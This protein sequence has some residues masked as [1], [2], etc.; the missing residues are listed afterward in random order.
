MN[1]SLTILQSNPTL[2]WLD[3]N[4]E[5]LIYLKLLIEKQV[6]CLYHKID[7][8]TRYYVAYISDN[9]MIY[10]IFEKYNENIK[11]TNMEEFIINQNALL[12]EVYYC[13]TINCEHNW[14][15]IRDNNHNNNNNNN[16]NNHNNNNNNN[17]LNLYYC[18]ICNIKRFTFSKII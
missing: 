3:C 8:A 4:V 2:I 6:T 1:A 14:T 15:S 16:N 5:N 10:Y 12:K 13:L 11:K 17:L 9:P 7:F 18:S